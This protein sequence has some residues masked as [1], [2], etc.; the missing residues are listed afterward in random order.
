MS[1]DLRKYNLR[2]GEVVIAHFVIISLGCKMPLLTIK[3]LAYFPPGWTSLGALLLVSTPN[4][5]YLFYEVSSIFIYFLG[6]FY[7]QRASR[8]HNPR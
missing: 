5:L 3:R 1:T 6:N 7:T 8:T 4:A 2:K